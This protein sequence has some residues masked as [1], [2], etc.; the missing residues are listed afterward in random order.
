[1]SSRPSWNG[2][3]TSAS[4][5]SASWQPTTP[6]RR[7]RCYATAACRPGWPAPSC[8]GRAPCSYGACTADRVALPAEEWPDRDGSAAGAGPTV[9]LIVVVLV[10]VLAVQLLTL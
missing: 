4:G 2:P 9:V 5:W 6:T 8:P 1:M 3:S 10:L 7:W